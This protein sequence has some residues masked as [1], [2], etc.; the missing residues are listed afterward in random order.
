M[1]PP[2]KIKYILSSILCLAALISVCFGQADRRYN[3]G[4]ASQAFNRLLIAPN[5]TSTGNTTNAFQVLDVTGTNYFR[6]VPT[7]AALQYR[8]G[9]I[10]YTGVTG[11][12][13]TSN[14][15]FTAASVSGVRTNFI[16]KNGLLVDGP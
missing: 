1:Q 16:F 13:Q 12:F 7:N 3:S 2:N 6:I 11:T 9:G 15:I 8:T 10:L 5:V 4:N 14:G